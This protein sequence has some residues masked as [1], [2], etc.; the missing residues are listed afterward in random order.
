MRDDKIYEHDKRMNWRERLFDLPFFSFDPKFE[1]QITP[2]F[3]GA[4]IRFLVRD[5]VTKLVVS[6]YLDDFDNIGFVGEPYWEIYCVNGFDPNHDFTDCERFL[7]KDH[8][9][10]IERVKDVLETFNLE[11]T[12]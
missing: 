11:V 9:Q 1:V 4:T 5:K 2:P 6:V 8:E 12:K 3:G 7:F 10:M